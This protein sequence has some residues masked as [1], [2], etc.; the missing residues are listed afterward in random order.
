L[1]RAAVDVCDDYGGDAARN[2]G[3]AGPKALGVARDRLGD[4]FGDLWS[5]SAVPLWADAV[6][7]GLEAAVELQGPGTVPP[8]DQGLGGLPDTIAAGLTYREAQVL[9]SL[10]EGR[11][12]RGISAE[13]HLSVRTVENHLNRI[14]A[15]LGVSSRVEAILLVRN[16][17]G[18]R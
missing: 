16:P 2:S 18:G 5:S 8:P 12:N 10:A 11:S 14:Y 4:A 1:H 17:T 3:P 15:K 7:L 13:L 9:A 6:R